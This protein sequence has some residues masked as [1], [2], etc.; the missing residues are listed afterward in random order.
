MYNYKEE[1]KNDIRQWIGDDDAYRFCIYDYL[2]RGKGYNYEAMSNDLFNLLIGSDY[3]TGGTD[4][5]TTDEEAKM[6]LT[7]NEAFAAD[8]LA[9]MYSDDCAYDNLASEGKYAFIDSAVRR[10]IL[11]ACIM[12][13]LHEIPTEFETED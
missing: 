3:V 12:D 11:M 6:F 10:N 1:V 13:V 2:Q 7:G 8:C 5:Y 4:Y 9:D